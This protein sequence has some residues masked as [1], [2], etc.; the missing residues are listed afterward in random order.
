MK[1]GFCRLRRGVIPI[2]FFTAAVCAAPTQEA[3]PPPA[4]PAETVRAAD[5]SE[6]KTPDDMLREV[7]DCASDTGSWMLRERRHWLRFLLGGG[8]SV[9]L[10]AVWLWLWRKFFRHGR[11]DRRGWKVEVLKSLVPP[12]TVLAVVTSCFIFSKPLLKS[13]PRRWGELDLRLFYAVLVLVVAWGALNAVSV[14]DRRIRSFAARDDNAL[15]DLTVGMIGATLKVAIAVTSLL[16]V[17][18]SIF[19][20]NITALLAGAGVVGLAVALAAKETLSNFFGTLVIVADAPFRL[21]DRIQAGG[22]DGIVERVGMRSSRIRTADDSVCT[23][24]NSVLTNSVVIRHSPRG[25]LKHSLELGL[26]YGTTPSQLETAMK[27]LHGIMDDFHGPDAP[28]RRPRI[29][30]SGFGSCSV[31]IRAIVW[32]K[33]G[34]FAAEEPLLDELHL[35]IFRRFAAAGLEFAYPTQTLYVRGPNVPPDAPDAR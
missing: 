9:L 12:V 10:G 23:M 8:A 20:L 28:E 25:Y 21:G 27:I 13:L 32:L 30:F 6:L 29:F 1:Y 35:E 15:D 24:P 19:D 31:N 4:V 22:V 7:E 26:T 2:V 16:F 11:S 3:A 5:P 33:A 34:S 18:Q 14:L 17:G